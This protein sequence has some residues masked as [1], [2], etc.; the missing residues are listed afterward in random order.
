MPP[1]ATPTTA[2]ASSSRQD[3][4]MADS[5]SL[6]SQ[7]VTTAQLKSTIDEM[8]L[9]ND[10]MRNR[11]DNMGI[12][13]VKMPSIERFSGERSRL[14]GFLT[15][16]KLKLHHEGEKLPTASDQV[17][18]AGLFLTGRALE[19]F[20]P[21]L[22][23][24]QENGMGTANL[25]VRYI[26][27]SWDGFANKLTQM[28]G[29]PESVATAEQKLY[30]LTQR[31]SAVEYTTQ[32]HTLSAQVGWNAEALMAQYRRGLKS[33]VQTTM[34]PMDDA[35]TLSELVDQAIKVDSRLYQA[36]K[37]GR[38]TTQERSQVNRAP[39]QVSKPWYGGPEP[40]DLSGTRES[41]KKSWKPRDQRT[42]KSQGSNRG[43]TREQR[44]NQGSQQKKTF[45]R[46]PQQEQWRKEGA[47]MG[48]GKRG[49]FVK[50]C[51]SKDAN[52]VKG[53][54]MPKDDNMRGTRECSIKHFTFCY[55]DACRIH[56]DAK[57]GASFWPQEPESRAL[58]GTQESDDR[59]DALWYGK[60]MH[61]N[62]APEDPMNPFK[63]NE[64]SD[65][66]EVQDE[67]LSDA[68]SA[69][70]SERWE[71][72]THQDS[73]DATSEAETETATETESVVDVETPLDTMSIASRDE[74]ET[75]QSGLSKQDARATPSL[76]KGKRP[77]TQDFQDG[78]RDESEEVTRTARKLTD[79]IVQMFE[80]RV[81]DQREQ[82]LKERYDTPVKKTV[83]EDPT[84][85]M[86]YETWEHF[87]KRIKE[88]QAKKG[89]SMPDHPKYRVPARR[90]TNRPRYGTPRAKWLEELEREEQTTRFTRH[91]ERHAKGC[92]EA[93]MRQ[94][95]TKER[96]YT[97]TEMYRRW[98]RQRKTDDWEDF[99]GWM[100][101]NI[102]S[103]KP[104]AVRE[105]SH[106]KGALIMTAKDLEKQSENW[107]QEW[108]IEVPTSEIPTQW[109]RNHRFELR[110]ED[111]PRVDPKHPAHH[112][113][114]W[115]ACVDDYC[116]MHRAPKTA[117]SRYPRRMHW[118]ENCKRHR[119]AT[120]MH[121]WHPI[122]ETDSEILTMEPGRFLSEECLEGREWW[123]CTENTCPWHIAEKKRTKHWPK[124]EAQSGKGQAYWS[125]GNQ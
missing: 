79:Q 108:R 10:A 57:Y 42:S 91:E 28:F 86:P 2:G 112:T 15:Q 54:D 94:Y 49:H 5:S 105:V 50:D 97:L 102:T 21:Y 89:Y 24:L 3:T 18:Y 58:R 123:D 72:W 64:D 59:Q 29:D 110:D 12:A 69:G 70:R 52:T 93:A 40:M 88:W 38:S 6:D 17:A 107:R 61:G 39:R 77:Q 7:V 84:R 111:E 119:N 120:Y 66:E 67:Q 8:N 20:E 60:D 51:R 73:E 56:E 27:A 125:Q 30:E 71:Q 47:C 14:K 34:I 23:E 78:T 37:T 31:T 55:N 11:I 19:W 63:T 116:G 22:T 74:R 122:Q 87:D 13:R 115:I 75:T 109:T 35:T 41:K 114:S 32:F 68:H 90:A 118:N 65:E 25:D 83:I 121:G 48:C 26:F 103:E 104:F 92:N 1:K 76:D 62:D 82:E 106:I 33:K 96:P 99:D 95:F 53:T 9:I 46:S 98:Y 117:N 81:K 124:Q 113:L 45:E 80:D 101:A 100:D 43:N 4:S 16:M 44:P 36:D 85:R